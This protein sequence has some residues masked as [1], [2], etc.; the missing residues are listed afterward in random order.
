M[1][2]AIDIFLKQITLTG[3]I[4]FTVTLPKAPDNVNTDL[5]SV[6]RIREMLNEGMDDIENGRVRR[7][8]D[9]FA[10]FKERH[11]K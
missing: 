9:A 1:A 2:T 6:S 8:K 10:E 5:I 3:G 11:Q 7:A 4:P